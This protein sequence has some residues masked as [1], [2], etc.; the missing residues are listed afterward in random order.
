VRSWPLH[1]PCSAVVA[2]AQCAAAALAERPTETCVV[3]VV[4]DRFVVDSTNLA[5]D[6]SANCVAAPADL[7]LFLV[8][9]L[10]SCGLSSRNS[11]AGI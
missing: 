3:V 4:V 8:F 1:A 9:L 11:S 2:A 10:L 7:Q 5:G 6:D